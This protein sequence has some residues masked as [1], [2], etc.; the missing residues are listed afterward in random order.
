MGKSY[1]NLKKWNDYRRKH[2]AKNRRELGN[3]QRIITIARRKRGWRQ[4]DLGERMYRSKEN[5]SLYECGVELAP[6]DELDRVM[7]ELAKMREKGC[8]F[9]CENP[10]A[11]RIGP[12]IYARR[13][14][15]RGTSYV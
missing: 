10:T 4:E 2:K 15:P 12:C 6:W 9:Y 13:G 14:R 8:A 7:P 3:S 1:Y 5:I 11:C